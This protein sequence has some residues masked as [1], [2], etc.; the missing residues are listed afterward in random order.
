MLGL[1]IGQSSTSGQVIYVVVG[2]TDPDFMGEIKIIIKSPTKTIQIHA[3]QCIAQLLLLPYQVTGSAVS[4]TPMGAAAF[5]SNNMAFW[6]QKIK[7]SRLS[8]TFKVQVKEI[9]GL[10]DTGSDIFCIS[11]KD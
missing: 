10:L 2:V 5:G 11:G 9:L 6:L 4:E 1:I 8:K 7:D 3:G